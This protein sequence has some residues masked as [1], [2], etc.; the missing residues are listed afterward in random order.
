MYR[1]R[2]HFKIVLMFDVL[3]QRDRNKFRHPPPHP[4]PILVTPRTFMLLMNIILIFYLLFQRE[5]YKCFPNFIWRPS[6]GITF[7]HTINKLSQL[8]GNRHSSKRIAVQFFCHWDLLLSVGYTRTSNLLDV[9]SVRCVAWYVEFWLIVIVF[10]T[11]NS[12]VSSFSSRRNF[13]SDF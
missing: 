1:R 9:E 6:S 10:T 4:H 3:W 12:V 13:F 11:W 5:N 7:W 2:T 8:D